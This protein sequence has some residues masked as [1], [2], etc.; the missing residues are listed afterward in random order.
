MFLSLDFHGDCDGFHPCCCGRE[1]CEKLSPASESQVV[2]EAKIINVGLS[3]A[4][5]KLRR[6]RYN[7]PAGVDAALASADRHYPV[8]SQGTMS[9]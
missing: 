4:A 8:R 3:L 7:L 2:A 1:E 9:K 6:A 5:V